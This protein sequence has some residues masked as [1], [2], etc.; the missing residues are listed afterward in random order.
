MTRPPRLGAFI[1]EWPLLEPFSITGYTWHAIQVLIVTLE[2]DG[3]VGRGEAA[4]VYYKGDVPARMLT[5]IEAIKGAVE[6]GIGRD[7]AQSL[8]PPGGARNALDCAFWELESLISG[9]PVWQLA[10]L[11]PPRPMMT[12]FG[13]GADTPEKMAALALSYDQA[14]AIKLKL[15]GEHIDADRVRAV[16]AARPDVWLSVDA[17]QGFSR[18]FFEKLLPT[19]IEADVRVIE[20][21]FPVGQDELLDGLQSPILVAADESALSAGDIDRLLGRFDMVN[22]KLDKCGGL[23]AG[24]EMA[25]DAQAA[26]LEV[27]VGNML[28]TS[29]AMAPALLVAQF[30]SAIDLDGPLFL[31]ADRDMPVSY[32]DGLISASDGVWGR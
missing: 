17:N 19:L 15:T 10:G 5:Q 31:T 13:C 29:L 25:R 1:E 26:G 22:I 32:Q 11:A 7:E 18:P 12:T 4:G 9:A 3:F 28:G 27:M 21:P 14:R 20:Q 24:L 2:A 6:S 8:L 16:R 30:C 23:T